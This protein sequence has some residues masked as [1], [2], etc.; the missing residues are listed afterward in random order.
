MGEA[1]DVLK[2][3]ALQQGSS[4]V[5][6]VSLLNMGSEARSSLIAVSALVPQMESF[7][8]GAGD[9]HHS[10]Q[11]DAIVG[12]LKKLKSTFEG[13]L[14]NARESEAAEKKAFEE[15]IKTLKASWDKMDKSNKGKQAESGENDGE[16]SSKKTLLEEA[17]KQKS[18]DEDF[19][20][21]L[22]KMAAKK[23][24][25]WEVRK[26]LRANEDAAIAEA[27]SILNS[28]EAFSN[29]GE[30]DATSTGKT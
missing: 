21:N 15:S 14:K 10:A 2:S 13:N 25:N 11:G 20:A 27:V 16:L 5:H 7:L 26:M 6:K 18:G 29:F 9:S 24:K 17:Q 3:I 12:I 23:A 8:Q 1:L 19:L 28:D 30:V 4:S 22:L